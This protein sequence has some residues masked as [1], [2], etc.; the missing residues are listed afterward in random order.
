[1]KFRILYVLLAPLVALQVFAQADKKPIRLTDMLRIRQ[2]SNIQLGPD[3]K[4]AYYTVTSIEQDGDKKWE[5]QFQ[6]QLWAVNTDGLTAPRQLTTSKNGAGQFVLSPDGRKIVFIRNID[7][8]AQLFLLALDGG[9]AVQL[10]HSKYGVSSPRWSPDGKKITYVCTIPWQ[11]LANDSVLNSGHLLPSWQVEKPGIKDKGFLNNYTQAADPDGSVMEARA[12]LQ[13]NE[14]DKKAKVINRLQFQEES[15]TNGDPG[16]SQVFVV[17]AEAGATPLQVTKGF[18]SYY[19]PQFIN[20]AQ[21]LVSGESDESIHPDRNLAMGMYILQADG[22]GIRPFLVKKDY[23]YYGASVSATGKWIALLHGKAGALVIPT[24]A[25]IPAAGTEKDLIDIPVDREKSNLFWKGDDQL[26]ATTPS[27]GGSVLVH[28]DLKSRKLQTMGSLQ[29]GIGSFSVA[30]NTL[31]Y[32]KTTAANPFEVYTADAYAKNEKRLTALNQE[33]L[34]DRV[35]SQPVKYSFINEKG[36][37]IEYWVMKPYGFQ[38]GQ[39]YPLLLQIHG[40]PTAMWGPGESTMWH[41]FQFWCA[42]GYGVVYSNPRGSGGYGESF[43]T[44]NKNDW[45]KGPMQD[46]LQS[47]QKAIDLGWADT[48]HLFISGGS[49][50]GYLV[51]YILGHDQRFAAACSQRGVYDLGAFFG[52]GNAWRL[53]PN[54]FGGYPWEPAVNQVLE[55]ESPIS[56]V[57]NINTPLIIFH[58]EN[59]LRTG[60]IGSEQFY[61]SL[62]VLGRPVEYVRHPGATHE[63]TRSGNNRQ[64]MDQ[65]LRTWEF[66]ERFR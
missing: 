52:E 38:A 29:E 61:K 34:N 11:E 44:A 58:G 4:T 32:I 9:E 14:K 3:A 1:M 64:R 49:Y 33:W 6:N 15:T 25:I 56:Y 63:I 53:V 7:K 2:A 57:Q 60:V 41:E 19:N 43:M 51:S 45:G 40:G 39:K 55:R 24:L 27:N 17:S 12:W 5:Y 28:Y 46:V 66:F 65:M 22:S 30:A 16:I 10:T 31:V 37:A 13:A 62:K 50:G 59:D 21:I 18:N 23:N 35:L 48:S 42:R 36:Q 47:M 20:T 8:K 54:Y 26:Y